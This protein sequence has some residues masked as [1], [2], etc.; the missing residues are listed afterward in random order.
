MSMYW[1]LTGK[2]VL[3]KSDKDAEVCQE[4]NDKYQFTYYIGFKKGGGHL[5]QSKNDTNSKY[6]D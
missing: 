5:E 4:L 6:R 2:V 3:P 1:H